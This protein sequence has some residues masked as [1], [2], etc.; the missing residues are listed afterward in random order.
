MSASCLGQCL[1]VAQTAAVK[2]ALL[3][4]KVSPISA[5][6]ACTCRYGKHASPA[7]PLAEVAA[8]GAAA[9]EPQRAAAVLGPYQR[10]AT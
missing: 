7:T 4:V 10:H 2:S 5:A 8:L 9:R 1:T 6:R 3:R